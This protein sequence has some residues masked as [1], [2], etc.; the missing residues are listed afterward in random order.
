MSG[1]AHS[2]GIMKLNLSP[3]IIDMVTKIYPDNKETEMLECLIEFWNM[4]DK[5]KLK[6][7]TAAS[8]D[9]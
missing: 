9:E 4:S 6:F 5:A 1:S 2:H 8:E 3:D 7:S